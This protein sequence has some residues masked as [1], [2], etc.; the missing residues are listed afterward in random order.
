MEGLLRHIDGYCERTDPGYWSEP[1]NAVTN[2]AFVIAAGVMLYRLRGVRLPM[3]RVLC[4][5]LATIG[6]G[7]Y[8]FHTHAQGWAS[9]ADVIPIAVF[10]L[11]YLFV[12]NRDMVGMR[13]GWALV[14]T[15][16]FFP[17]VAVTL[18]VFQALPFF[19]IS[20]AYWP[21]AL[22]IALYALGLRRRCP[23]TARG[24]GLGAGILAVSLTFRSLDEPLCSVNPIGTHFMWHILNGIMLGWMIEVYR[25]H[26]LAG[27]EPA[28]TAGDRLA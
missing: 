7:S 10:V 13:L 1:L 18:P 22:L 11:V 15:A 21:I 5:I 17:F 6:V 3:A 8:L 14:A 2:A 19:A 28:R 23:E 26:V 12:T 20:A 16:G 27:D 9:L 25:R 4:A 24:L